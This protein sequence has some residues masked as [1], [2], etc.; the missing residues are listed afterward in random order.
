MGKISAITKAQQEQVINAK[1][2]AV[3]KQAN[4]L[5]AEREKFEQE[6]LARSNKALY[7][8][9]TKV[10]AL[11]KQ[12]YDEKCLKETVK[13]MQY[14]LSKRGIKV[15]K[16]TP[17]L[18]VFVRYVFN[19]DRKRAYNYTST[20]M[21]AIQAEVQPTNLAE[22]IESKNG[23]EECKKEFRK[24]N[25]AKVKEQALMSASEEI[26]ELLSTV[27]AKKTITLANE[28]VALSDDV[29]YA[30]IVARV[31]GDGQFDLL[32]V[33]PRSTKGMYN[34]AVKELAKQLIERKEQAINAAKKQ[35]VKKQTQK[36][37]NTMTA[38]SA[39]SMTVKELEAA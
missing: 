10:Y 8:I 11:F 34:A 37:V 39:A 15:Q 1:V 3:I 19:S 4:T 33:V 12:A 17:A 27:Q 7:A 21:A 31:V 30:F 24:S 36:T 20:L 28:S 26:S 5:S 23:V 2:E 29:Q 14:E 16:N 25:E 38:K 6:E 32:R 22:F 35:R 18:T 13:K 9:L